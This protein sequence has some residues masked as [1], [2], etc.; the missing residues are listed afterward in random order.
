MVRWCNWLPVNERNYS[1]TLSVDHS[2]VDHV[3]IDAGKK[4]KGILAFPCDKL[5]DS[6]LH[7]RG[8]RRDAIIIPIAS[9][10]TA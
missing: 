6:Y 3:D 8:T 9:T 2:G 5:G 10:S 7:V 1:S 4:K